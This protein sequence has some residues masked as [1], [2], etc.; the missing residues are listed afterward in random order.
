MM[1]FPKKEIRAVSP[2]KTLRGFSLVE[3]LVAITILLIAVL[4]PMRIVS[5]SIKA[6]TFAREQLVAVS[7]AQEGIE[8][9]IRLRD[10]NALEHE[11]TPSVD[12]WDWYAALPSACT[13]GTGCSYNAATDALVACTGGNCRV[14]L[15]ETGSSG[16]YYSHSS[17]GQASPFTRK[18]TMTETASGSE[19][20]IVSVV[21]WDSNSFGANVNVT[22]DTSILNQYE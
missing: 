7:I 18:V 16:Y 21:S 9:M 15:D 19:V 22:L 6:A 10:D 1:R 11:N 2:V 13:N 3:T 8:E 4:A 17:A 14:Y 20:R 5:Q 12:P